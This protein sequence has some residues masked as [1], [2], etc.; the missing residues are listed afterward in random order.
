M[1]LSKISSGNIRFQ[2][3]LIY[4]YSQN[5]TN[6]SLGSILSF[7][8]PQYYASLKRIRHVMNVFAHNN[9]IARN[10][11]NIISYCANIIASRLW[12]LLYRYVVILSDDDQCDFSRRKVF[13]YCIYYN[14]R[15]EKKKSLY[16]VNIQQTNNFDHPRNR[17]TRRLIDVV[18][19]WWLL[20]DQEWLVL[21]ARYNNFFNL[22]IK[23]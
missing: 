22:D 3:N 18:H 10:K 9:L 7:F 15:E 6:F 2:L 8:L 4:I 20:R 23:E 12:I 16:F 17:M 14:A 11:Y 13:Y 5:V 1:I 19:S 21:F